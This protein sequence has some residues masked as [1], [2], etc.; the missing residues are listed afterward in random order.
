MIYN[1]QTVTAE[2]TKY[3]DNGRLALVLYDEAH[4]IHS[5]ITVNISEEKLSNNN[6]A[7]IDVNNLDEDIIEWLDNNNFGHVTG[8]EVCNGFCVYPEYEFNIV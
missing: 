4:W 3:A 5:V 6:C 1:G 7:F 2:F 8:N